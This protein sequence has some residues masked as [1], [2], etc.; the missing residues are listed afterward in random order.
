MGL[1]RRQLFAVKPVEVLLAEMAGE[2]RLRRVLG[3]VTLTAL[4]EDERAPLEQCS[5]G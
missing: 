2:H 5:S 4:G 1:G 3:P